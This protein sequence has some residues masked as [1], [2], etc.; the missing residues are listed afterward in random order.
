M[1]RCI[2][3]F[4]IA[5]L[6]F[7]LAACSKPGSQQTASTK[8]E[9]ASSNGGD[10]AAAE[11]LQP[12]EGAELVIWGNGEAEGEWMKSVAEQFTEKYDVPV[13]FEEV[14][15]GDAAKKLE[16]D[17]PAGLGGDV[18]MAPHDRVGQ[19][20]TAG[21]IYDNY[22]A[23]EYKERLIDGVAE[24]VSSLN[25]EGEQKMYGFPLAIETV[26]MAYN[27]DLLDKMGFKP[28]ETMDELIEQS[29]EFMAQNPGTYGFMLEPGN[30]Y[31]NYSFIGGYEG[32]IFG[33]NN[34]NPEDI[35]LN[36]EPAL[37]AA[38]LLEK[39]RDEI[40]PLKKEDLT[41]DVIN[42]YFNEGKQLYTMEGSWGVNGRIDAGINL[43]VTVMPK[44]ENGKV[45]T[46][47]LG[48]KGLYVNSY[49]K[50]P[51]AAT[52]F[53]K[54]ATSD[55]MLLKFFEQTGNLP[56]TKAL[57]ENEKLKS[58]KLKMP[59]IEQAEHTVPMPNIPAM[60]SVWG[61]MDAALTAIWN[62]DEESKPALDKGVQQI[63]EA[64]NSQTK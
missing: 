20:T 1:K 57:L 46:T 33:E 40:L 16:T 18:F 47:F 21:L 41:A 60:D 22:Y 52:L 39:I 6:I 49:S 37:K 27:K 25:E 31:G 10:D 50:Y 42:S 11:E 4:V 19:M 5:L 63:Q 45:P 36:K 3:F 26:A 62:N 9:A 56:P 7:V 32:Y 58:D 15:H 13:S 53:A 35:G 17:G 30:F 24:A 48:V 29:K 8:N 2:H 64:I 55:E 28:A 44:L 54:F 59:F 43:G 14:A 38:E 12:E 61:G 51:K 34:T 23:S